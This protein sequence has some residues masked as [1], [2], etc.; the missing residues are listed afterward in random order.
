MNRTM[1]DVSFYTELI[2][3]V[4]LIIDLY[5]LMVNPFKPRKKRVI[6]YFFI[7]LLPTLAMFG[8]CAI[9]YSNYK[10]SDM[11]LSFTSFWNTQS[12]IEY[13]SLYLVLMIGI[14]YM[15][16]VTYRLCK[17]GM[18]GSLRFKFLWRY[19]AYNT[20]VLFH[21]LMPL[22]FRSPQSQWE[23]ETQWRPIELS[24]REYFTFP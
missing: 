15:I 8:W 11:R 22:F 9:Y 20:F 4:L 7:W 1:R 24:L 6:W 12:F 18:S 14:A 19:L 2:L 17:P 16:A 23:K 13:Y 5:Y 21:Y 10:G 3:N